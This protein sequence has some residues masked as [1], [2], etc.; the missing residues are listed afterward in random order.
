MVC[1]AVLMYLIMFT[2]FYFTALGLLL[3]IVVQLYLFIQYVYR[4]LDDVYRFSDS[5]SH[6]DY[7]LNFPTEKKAGRLKVLYKSFNKAI[8]FQKEISLEKEAAF[9]LFRTILEK[10]RFGV[11][12]VA[13]DTLRESAE[14][15]NILFMNE[16]ASAL[17]DAPVFKYWHRLERRAPN[18]ASKVTALENG[19]KAFIELWVN[20]QAVQLAV[21]VLPVKS[22]FYNYM[23]ISINNIKDEVEQKEMEA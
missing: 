19:G 7:S 5:L 9:H 21:D 16:S 18:F 3:V 15:R 10:V 23:I 2:R 13:G 12:V 17:L 1:A 6:G 11:I 8:D 14:P 22:P 20:E 4:L